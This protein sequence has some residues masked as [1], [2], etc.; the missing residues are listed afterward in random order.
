MGR[1]VSYVISLYPVCSPVRSP[2][3]SAVLLRRTSSAAECS[4]AGVYPL[5]IQLFVVEGALVKLV[6][7][8]GPGPLLQRASGPQPPWPL[9]RSSV[10]T[11]LS[12]VNQLTKKLGVNEDVAAFGA[13]LGANL[14]MPG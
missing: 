1:V 9:H 7:K 3:R 5:R 14:G 11:I 10:G 13:S 4:G 8:A 2:V 6:G 12:R